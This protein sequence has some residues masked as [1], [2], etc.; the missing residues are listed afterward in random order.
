MAIRYSADN[1]RRSRLLK[2]YNGKIEE[3]RVFYHTTSFG[4]NSHG[5]SIFHDNEE[6]AKL[7]QKTWIEEEIK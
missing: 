1:T 7:S 4:P 2:P 6:T 3:R 5:Y